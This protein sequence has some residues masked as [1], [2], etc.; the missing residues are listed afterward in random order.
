MSNLAKF[1]LNELEVDEIYVTDVLKCLLH[2]IVFQRCLGEITPSES[3]CENL[4]DLHY[5]CLLSVCVLVGDLL[6]P[7]FSAPTITAT[8]S[9]F[10]TLGFFSADKAF[11]SS[12][13]N[14]QTFLSFVV[15]INTHTHTHNTYDNN[16]SPAQRLMP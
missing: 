4:P 10:T 9:K 14:R 8:F 2:T 7:F 12:K 13:A 3:E 6:L 1:S 11:N 16:T 5:V 15:S